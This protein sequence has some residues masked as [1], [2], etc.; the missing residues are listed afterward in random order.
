VVQL[1]AAEAWLLREPERARQAVTQATD[2]AR[3]S[4]QEARRSVWDLRP[5]ALQ[6]TDLLAAIRE[7]LDR[8]QRR[9]SVTGTLEVRG[10]LPTISSPAEVA[11]FRVVQEA[12]ANAL[13]HGR[14]S[15]IRVTASSDGSDLCLEVRD[16][17]TG[18]DQSAP[19]R[20]GAFG[21]TSMGERAAACGGSLEV[22]SRPGEGTRVILTLPA[23]APAPTG[24]LG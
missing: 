12:V 10:R 19:S 22:V 6:R 14:P 1:Q 18:F 8:V 3:S 11:A 20:P 15:N 7:E 16:D 17:G 24:A 23:E 2:L 13:Q 5:Q 9:S 4:L 21:I